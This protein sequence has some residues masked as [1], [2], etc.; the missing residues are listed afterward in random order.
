MESIR[1]YLLS[2]TAAAVICSLITGIMGKK[3]TYA[4]I[5]RML[6]GLFMAITMLSPLLHIQLTDYSAYYGSILEEADLAASG[7]RRMANEAEAAIIK[8]KTETYILDKALSMGLSIEVEVT[9]SDS[10]TQQPCK[11]WLRGA[12]SPYAR[13]KLQEIIVSDLG[14]SKENQTWM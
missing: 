6:C 2:I 5:V 4:A 11:V 1:Q 12:A 10:D 8:H 7:G 9:L 13:Q 3:G 14:I